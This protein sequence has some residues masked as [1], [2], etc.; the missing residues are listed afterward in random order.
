MVPPVL[1]ET[2]RRLAASAPYEGLAGFRQQEEATEQLLASL[3][4]NSNAANFGRE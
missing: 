3:E 4:C 2:R 1:N